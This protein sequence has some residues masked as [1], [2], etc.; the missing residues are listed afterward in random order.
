[1]EVMF[2]REDSHSVAMIV[3]GNEVE[4]D[5]PYVPKH[6]LDMRGFYLHLFCQ[7]NNIK[8][9]QV[10]LHED[11]DQPSEVWRGFE[12]MKNPHWITHAIKE[13]INMKNERK[14]S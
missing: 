1:M 13:R 11:V 4:N 5:I 3:D 12:Y 2:I 6:Q 7:E 14:K 8:R 10:V 9:K